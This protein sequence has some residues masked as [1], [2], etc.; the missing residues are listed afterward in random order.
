LHYTAPQAPGCFGSTERQL[1]EGEVAM[2][3]FNQWMLWT[4]VCVVLD[5]SL[6]HNSLR[7]MQDIGWVTIA[8]LV[9][10]LLWAVSQHYLNSK[11]LLEV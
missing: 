3:S 2:G 4:T 6:R 10:D 9:S 8:I 5:V 7:I 1:P 11:E